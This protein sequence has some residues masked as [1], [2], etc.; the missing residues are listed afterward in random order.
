M[1]V[2]DQ[3]ARFASQADPDAVADRLLAGTK[4]ALRFKE[5]ADSRT[6]P[7]LGGS[8]RT[9]DLVA[10]LEDAAAPE[11]PWLLV[12]EF[13]ARHDPE[14]LEVT[15]EEVARIRLHARHGQDRRGRF[16]VLTGLVYL[17]G[18]CPEN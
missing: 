9:A 10:I 4:A 11:L 5:W 13:Q 15:L 7:R 2:F 17:Q 18:R 6:L 8:D 12:F 14:K 16:R 3:A 1:G